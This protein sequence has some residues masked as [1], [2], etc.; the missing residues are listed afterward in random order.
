MRSRRIRDIA[1]TKLQIPCS[2]LLK[3]IQHPTSKLQRSTKLQIPNTSPHG[4]SLEVGYWRFS[5]AWRLD[6]G[7][8][9]SDHSV[10][11]SPASSPGLLAAPFLIFLPSSRSRLTARYPP[12]IT[13]SPS[14]SPSVISQCRSSLMP[15]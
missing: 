8:F 2:K 11:F 9:P 7:A 10:F 5:G 14:L 3:N 15:I 6:V 4:D 13:S 1:K 12:E